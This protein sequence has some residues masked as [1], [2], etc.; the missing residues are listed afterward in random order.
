[1]PKQPTKKAVNSVQ[2]P[3]SA[4][5][6]MQSMLSS[7]FRFSLQHWG[8][9][10]AAI[11]VG[12]PVLGIAYFLLKPEKIEIISAVAE[13]GTLLQTVEAVGTVISEKDLSLKFPVTGVVDE[14]LITEGDIVTAGQVL[15]TL[16][17]GTIT[18]A[19][20]ASAR[21]NLQAANADLQALV[22]GTRPEEIRIA[23]AEVEN[24]QAS[25]ALSQKTLETA[26]ANLQKSQAKLVRLQTEADASLAGDILSADSAISQRLSTVQTSLFVMDDIF[27][28][29]IVEHAVE[30]Q[31]RIQLDSFRSKQKDAKA[32]IAY[33]LNTSVS[34]NYNDAL[35]KLSAARSAVLLGVTA[36][37]EAYKVLVQTDVG[38]YFT[39]SVKETYKASIATQRSAAETALS[40]IS[41]EL[42][43]FRD[44]AAKYQTLIAAEESAV[45]IASGTRDKAQAD[46]ATYQTL[47]RTQEAQLTLKKAGARSTD[48]AGAKA[49]VN[50]AYA[51]LQRAQSRFDDTV[52]R[53][54]ID[55][56]ITKADLKKG[57]FTGDLENFER[58]ITM[59][60]DSPYR[61]EIYTSEIDIPKVVY[62]QTGAIELDAYP[63]QD[64]WLT[65]TEIDPAATSIDGVPK[66]RIK[67][68]FVDAVED[69][70]KI[71]MT[72]DVDI[73]T[74]VRIDV[75]HVPGRAVL[76]NANGANIVRVQLQNG[77]VEER[78]VEIGLETETD[79]EIIR[80][81]EEGETIVVLLKK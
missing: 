8:K 47:L 41:T 52:L 50:Q 21:A 36:I 15:A 20:V 73:I 71:G 4:S 55:G 45:T 77:T 32:S 19:D 5:A 69:K 12:I 63:G 7:A 79:V 51:E 1:M 46:I 59:L 66:Y 62:S 26:E 30:F 64:F 37:D 10:L 76:R 18:Q 29:S 39:Q 6:N 61:V 68:D 3:V 65:V 57:E 11:L 72:G 24:R 81:I 2:K 40:N 17:S 54:P 53:A 74:D 48:I 34:A 67:L 27:S 60:G 16:R 70:L 33:V 43:A 44:A 28:T 49:R 56:R 38:N 23:E 22:E 9:I 35:A 58:A 80:G 14:V 13:R 75:V 25:L 42:E 78:E 31:N